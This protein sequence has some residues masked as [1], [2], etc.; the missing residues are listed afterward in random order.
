MVE[1]LGKGCPRKDLVSQLRDAG[2]KN[3]Q[4]LNS[5]QSIAEYG[6]GAKGEPISHSDLSKLL[7]DISVV[8]E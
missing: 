6:M 7:Q 8:H 2:W 5:L 1:A 4:N 3:T